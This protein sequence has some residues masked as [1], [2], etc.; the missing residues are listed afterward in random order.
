[1]HEIVD[2]IRKDKIIA[3]IRGLEKGKL[4]PV[5]EALVRG[6][7]RL[8]EITFDQRGAP[9]DTAN[10]IRLVAQN[11]SG[12]VCVGAGTVMTTAQLAA[13]SLREPTTSY[14]LMLIWK[15]SRRRNEAA[16]CLFLGR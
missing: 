4:A 14:P 12:D 5:V 9:E 3:I 8:I 16:S 11:Y 10:A 1:M 6:G 13:L 2:M 15:L 7:I